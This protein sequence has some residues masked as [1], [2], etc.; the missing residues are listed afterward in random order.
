MTK[1]KLRAAFDAIR[2]GYSPD[3]VV[4]DPQLNAAFISHCRALGCAEPAATLNRALLNLRKQGALRGIASAKTSFPDE[5]QY[6][7]AVEIAVRFLERRDGVTLDE[8]ICDPERATELDQLASNIAPGYA[9]LHY[10]WAAF[11]LRKAKRLAPEIL[12]R[13]APP[14]QVLTFR[15]SQIDLGAIPAGQGLYLFFARDRLLY[16]GEAADLRTRLRKHLD[17]SDR[18]ELARW[19]WEFGTDD[20]HLEVQVLEDATAT[21]VRKALEL[22]LIRSRQPTFNVQR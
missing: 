9:P 4:A 10:R 5:D 15:V 12:G 21:R 6:R 2:S 18:R 19:M 8:I 14:I 11:N 17:H 13:V 22:E 20:L 1:S 3:R 16:V 7:F